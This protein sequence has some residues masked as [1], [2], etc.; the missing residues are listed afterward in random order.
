MDYVLVAALI[1]VMFLNFI[2][3]IW[4]TKARNRE[5]RIHATQIYRVYE[6]IKRYND[7]QFGTE[8]ED[9]GKTES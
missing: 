2:E 3:S 1:V 7:K 6:E 4:I 8:G 5:Q 9:G